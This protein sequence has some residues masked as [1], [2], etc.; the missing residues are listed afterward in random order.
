VTSLG[1][2]IFYYMLR[3]KG[4]YFKAWWHHGKIAVL[5]IFVGVTV[6]IVSMLTLFGSFMGWY[7]NSTEN[8]CEIAYH[9]NNRSY[10]TGIVFILLFLFAGALLMV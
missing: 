3:P 5:L 4:A 6:S 10:K 2:A 8:F 9:Q 1:I 7:V